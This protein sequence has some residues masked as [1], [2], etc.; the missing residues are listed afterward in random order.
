MEENRLMAEK[1]LKIRTIQ[2][3]DTEANWES[4]SIIPKKGEIIVYDPDENHAESRFK[5]GDGVKTPSALPF[6]NASG[7]AGEPG[8]DG[9]NGVTFTPSVSSEGVI[10]WTNDGD[11]PNPTSV[12]IKGPAGEPGADGKPGSDGVNGVTFTPSVSSAGVISWTNDGGKTNPSPVN[13]KGA[14][15]KNGDPGTD[16]VGIS[17]I[18]AGT[19][20]VSGDYTITP[21][22]VT[23]TDTTTQTLNI[24]A[25]NGSDATID[26]SKF[27]Q[28]D[29]SNDFKYSVNVLNGNGLTAYSEDGTSKVEYS[30]SG[31]VAKGESEVALTFPA[32]GGVIA[33]TDDIPSTSGFAI[34]SADNMFDGRLN[35]FKSQIALGVP[36]DPDNYKTVYLLNTQE[37]ER[38]IPEKAFLRIEGEAGPEFNGKPLL[39]IVDTMATNSALVSLTNWAR[40]GV[41]ASE[42]MGRT[43]LRQS[44]IRDSETSKAIGNKVTLVSTLLDKNAY[45]VEGTI[46]SYVFPQK[47]GTVA[48]TSDFSANPTLDGT[49]DALEGIELNGTKY[50]VKGGGGD[51]TAAGNNTFTGTNTF[52]NDSGVT[53][54]N[55]TYSINI[56]PNGIL[57]GT[58][59][60]GAFNV[61]IPSTGGDP[62]TLALKSDIPNTSNFVTKSG[63][64]TFSGSNIFEISSMGNGVKVKDGNVSTTYSNYDIRR[65]TPADSYIYTYPFKSGNIALTSDIPD[66]SNFVKLSDDNAFTGT[67]TFNKHIEMLYGP[68]GYIDFGNNNK[69]YGYYWSKNGYSLSVP[70]LTQN[71][72][73][74]LKSEIP[75]TSAFVKLS[76][77]NQFTGSNVFT[78]GSVTIGS[79]GLAEKTTYK[80]DGFQHMTASAI[81]NNFNFPTKS[82]GTYTLATTDD[83]SPKVYIESSLLGA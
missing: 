52:N 17:T 49:E 13:I 44:C 70:T 23:K 14:D 3:H 68:E 22:T 38:T 64:N 34:L 7:P 45:N 9:K 26:T 47:S 55:D 25:K 69:F 30:S 66:I 18:T 2:K 74:A 73:V 21:I 10:S 63:N 29:Q 79:I 36:Q 42:Y 41:D 19:S 39:D 71:D 31:I 27:A 8:T 54:Q 6:Q 35:S 62:E 77:D 4:S 16:G 40:T 82:T 11:K 28:L 67:N 24:K 32:K 78:S 76:G 48:L 43:T 46:N 65:T 53:I 72:T 20:T 51:V 60:A 57:V 83:I 75:D 61:N 59:A 81:Y 58:G 33:T 12:N 56:R 37:S 5:I 80:K 50:V 15:G 1:T